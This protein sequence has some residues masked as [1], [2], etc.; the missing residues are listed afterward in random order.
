MR[1]ESDGAAEGCRVA[2]CSI[3]RVLISPMIC[4]VFGI[5]A[6]SY[7]PLVVWYESRS[8]L[9]IAH[10][11]FFHALVALLLSSYCMTVCVDPGAPPGWWLEREIERGNPRQ[12]RRCQRSDQLK[13]PR[14]H[15]CSV[16]RRL[17]LNMDHF[18]PWVDNT[19]GYYNRKFFILFLV[20][21][22]A[23]CLYAAGARARLARPVG[24]LRNPSARALAQHRRAR[25]L[26]RD[27]VMLYFEGS[28]D[29]TRRGSLGASTIRLMAMMV[30][31]SL[32]VAL[33]FFASFHLSMAA[34]NETTI[35]SCGMADPRYDMG[36]EANLEQVFG[37]SKWLWWLPVYGDGPVGDGIHW[38]ERDGMATESSHVFSDSL[39]DDSV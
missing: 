21:A 4:F 17:V 8:A 14:S 9:A 12:L 19:V 15:Y 1:L 33:I 18:C 16:T 20:Y 39:S 10:L 23:T 35:E 27:A 34:R 28:L 24:A 37:R 11:M 5:V 2:P 13:P 7:V 22:C 29:V 30:D 25:A 26:A 32:G 38:P 31:V 36:S 6:L 3:A